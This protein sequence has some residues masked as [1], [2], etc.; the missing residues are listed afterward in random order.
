[1]SV[2]VCP[3]DKLFTDTRTFTSVVQLR[4]SAGTHRQQQVCNTP[5]AFTNVCIRTDGNIH[6]YTLYSLTHQTH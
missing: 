2:S 3:P 1:M 5:L 6:M 4:Q